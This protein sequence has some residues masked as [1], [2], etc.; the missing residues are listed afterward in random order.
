MQVSI[1]GKNIDVGDAFR[2]HIEDTLSTAV[3][4]YFTRPVEATVT[5]VRDAHLY[6]AQVSARAGRG[7]LLQ[8]TGEATEPYPAFDLALERLLNRLRRHKRRL[9]DHHR[10]GPA[11][12][13]G[14]DMLPARQY[15]LEAEPAD[16]HLEQSEAPGQP[17]VVAEMDTVIEMLTVGEAVMRMDLA[18]APAFMF[19]NRAHGRLNMVYRRPDGN[20]GWVDPADSDKG[21]RT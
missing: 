10:A 15:V 18:D 7:L 8:S 20:I 17:A 14:A 21:S 5:L 1:I 3:G 16:D 11:G 6:R 9:K 12:S 2:T 4:R 19:R 13:G